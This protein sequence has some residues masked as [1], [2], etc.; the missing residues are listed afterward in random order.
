MSA[1]VCA[2][3]S[4]CVCTLHGSGPCVSMYVCLHACVHM[5]LRVCAHCRGIDRVSPCV[6]VCTHTCARVSPCVCTHVCMRVCLHVC[7][8]RVCAHCRGIDHVSPCMSVCTHMCTCVSVCVCTHMHACV[9]ARMCA[10]VST[11]V[12]T[13][14]GVWTVRLHAC[15]FAAHM[16]CLHTWAPRG[17]VFACVAAGRTRNRPQAGLPLAASRGS[18]PQ[19]L[20]ASPA[21]SVGPAPPPTSLARLDQL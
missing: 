6:C 4:T 7:V 20:P 14:P 5:C 8:S 9:F 17:G 10:H 16:H 15:V 2:R 1:H 13:L 19:P 11:C 12:C 3:V 21:G 18:L